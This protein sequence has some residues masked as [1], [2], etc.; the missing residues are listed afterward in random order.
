M[1]HSLS[2]IKTT[3]KAAKIFNKVH[4][5]EEKQTTQHR[6][7]QSPFFDFV[8]TRNRLLFLLAVSSHPTAAGKQRDEKKGREKGPFLYWAVREAHPDVLGEAWERER[9]WGEKREKEKKRQGE[10]KRDEERV[11]WVQNSSNVYAFQWGALCVL[12]EG[13]AHVCFKYEKGCV[14]QSLCLQMNLGR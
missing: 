1:N 12:A 8:G 5:K 4:R 2:F 14:R 13:C 9:V 7:D 6:M 11:C 10:R 3:L